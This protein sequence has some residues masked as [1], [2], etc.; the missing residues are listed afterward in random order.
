M[1][2]D[3]RRQPGLKERS[4]ASDVLRD[5]VRDQSYIKQ[6]NIQSVLAMLKRY[7][8][9]SRTEIARLTGMSPTSITRIVVELLNQGLIHEASGEQRSSGRGRKAT[10]LRIDK[11]GMYSIG[12][13]LDQSVIRLCVLN[14]ADEALYRGETLVDGECTPKKMAEAAKALFDRMPKI[15]MSDRRVIGA[16]GVCLAGRVDPWRGYVNSSS[17]MNWTGCDL[18]AYFSEAFGVPACIENDVKAC[19][20]GE[21]VRM[22]IPDA[23]DTVY[24]LVDKGIGMAATSNGML[25]RGVNNDAGEIEFVPFGRVCGGRRD[26]L[27]DHLSENRLIERAREY[28]PGIHSLDA[29]LWARNQGMAWADELIADFRE[30]LQNVVELIACIYNPQ[31]LVIG[32]SVAHKLFP[33]IAERMGND[34]VCLGVDYEESCMT[35][36]GLIAMRRAI[37]ERIEQTLD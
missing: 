8:P 32:G 28:D 13:H 5:K 27:A 25:V 35:G 4:R 29:I 2:S 10:N 14:L 22:R 11:E 18:Q 34:A 15:T 36:A 26:C 20:I 24:V 1:E 3:E 33:D 37:V 12:V 31:K 19:L 9:V 30:V 21:K 7:Q 6:Y 17:W 23:A 16:V